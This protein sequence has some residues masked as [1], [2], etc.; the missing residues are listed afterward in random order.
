MNSQ[1]LWAIDFMRPRS[2]KETVQDREEERQEI[3][4]HIQEFLKSG[5][6]I[7]I[8]PAGVS[9]E[10]PVNITARNRGVL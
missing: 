9:G 4:R 7:Q 5:G 3:S 8:I 1:P 2:T 10:S 6:K